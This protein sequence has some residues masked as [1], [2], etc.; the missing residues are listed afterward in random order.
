MSPARL[1]QGCDADRHLVINVTD[2]GV[3]GVIGKRGGGLS[4]LHDRVAAYGGSLHVDSV[5]DKG[6]ILTA[7]LPCGS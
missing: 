5:P 6:T 4:G 7:E 2:D 1:A 3:G